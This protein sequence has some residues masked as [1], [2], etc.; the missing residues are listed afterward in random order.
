MNGRK[1]GAVLAGIGAAGAGLGI[2]TVLVAVDGTGNDIRFLAV[3]FAYL[4]AGVVV[5][6]RRSSNRIGPLLIAFSFSWWGWAW[7][8]WA[9][10]PGRS[11]AARYIA[12][13]TAGIHN[14]IVAWLILAFPTGRLTRRIDR[15]LVLL[16]W[17]WVGVGGVVNDWVLATQ[18]FDF[19]ATFLRV[20][21]GVSA[22]LALAVLVRVLHR[23]I[24]ASSTARRALAPVWACAGVLT[25]VF[26]A[27]G[28]LAFLHL[29][30]EVASALGASIEWAEGII[31]IAYVFGLF[32]LGSL[33]GGV[34][35]LVLE[36]QSQP[37]PGKLRD[38]LARTLADPTLE[39]AFWLH[40]DER[41]VALDGT[42]FLVPE[43]GSGRAVTIL[44]H[45]GE[46]LA[47]LV[48]DATLAEAPALVASVGA[49]ASLALENERLQ[50]TVRAQL[51]EAVASRHRIV[52]A[53]DAER[54]RVER[55]IHD[56]AQQRLMALSLALRRAQRKLGDDART[57][58][59]ILEEASAE[60]A[61]AVS[62]L[63]DL[64]RGIHPAILT[65]EGLGPAIRAL[66]ERSSLPVEL[67]ID[68]AGPIPDGVQVTAYYLVSEAM[69]NATRYAHASIVS[70]DVS[71]KDD[72]MI[73]EV[74]D[75]GMGGADPSRG[76]G[77]RGLSD[78]VAAVGG[79]LT[80]ESLSGR[81]TRVAAELPCG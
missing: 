64:A 27:A 19:F 74:R 41:F 81:G 61:L 3:G 52:E 35:D 20:D 79:R 9:F 8:L 63:R 57:A 2:Y 50:A 23:L 12:A 4:F 17:I 66:V 34:G 48:Y 43:S 69:T 46:R 31:P 60:L 45:G 37:P 15:G 14:A 56:G 7:T 39:L 44:E 55:N 29:P 80:V 77:L 68:P 70:I 30:D 47:A 59:A 53:A 58:E 72:W 21:A 71:R 26:V 73:V 76:S 22:F 51:E 6:A 75:D 28:A 62:E 67:R 10:G 11:G 42:P 38:A 25:V 54:R 5:T 1:R 36:L 16:V 33:R 40:D 18:R 65:D 24:T 49:A 78:R 32:R 13:P